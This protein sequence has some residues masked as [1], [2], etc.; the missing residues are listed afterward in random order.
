[1]KPYDTVERLI[2]KYGVA[3]VLMMIMDI[4]RDKGGHIYASY[5]DAG[6]EEKWNIAANVIGQ[7]VRKL[8]KVPGI[9]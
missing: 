9:K 8:P 1:M 2:D 4:A 7:A 6:L 5:Q 3:N